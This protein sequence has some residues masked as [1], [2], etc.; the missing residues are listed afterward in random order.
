MITALIQVLG[1]GLSLWESHEKHKFISELNSLEEKLQYEWSKPTYIRNSFLIDKYE[2]RV[3]DLSRHFAVQASSHR[4]D[5][6]SKS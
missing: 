1:V 4:S 5:L 2:R 3:L 6:V